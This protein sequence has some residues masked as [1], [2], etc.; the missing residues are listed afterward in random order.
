MFL[1]TVY[2]LGMKN[3][4]ENTSTVSGGTGW[5]KAKWNIANFQGDGKHYIF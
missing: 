3:S 4:T 2:I 1:E 5:G